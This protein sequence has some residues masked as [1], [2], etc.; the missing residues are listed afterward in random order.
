[1]GDP[2]LLGLDPNQRID[3]S[4]GK[5]FVAQPEQQAPSVQHA[6]LSGPAPSFSGGHAAPAAHPDDRVGM[7]GT[8]NAQ[9]QPRQDHQVRPLSN[10]ELMAKANELIDAQRSQ[11]GSQM[12]QGPAVGQRDESGGKVPEWLTSYMGQER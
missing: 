9:G 10:D 3:P 12:A 5:A 1:M 8:T 11:T 7:M 4:T 6:S 2:L